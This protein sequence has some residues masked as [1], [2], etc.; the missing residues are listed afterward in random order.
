[1]TFHEQVHRQLRQQLAGADDPKT[2]N[3]ALRL[4]AKWRSALIQNTLLTHHGT[5]VMDGPFKGMRFLPHSAEGCH[6]PK[7]L[8][9]YEQPLVPHVERAVVSGYGTVLNIGCAE[10]YYAVGM[11]RRMPASRVMAFDLNP[12]AQETCKQLAHENDVS[13][14]VQVA[15]A[16]RLADFAAFTAQRVLVLCDIEGAER[17]L[18]DPAAAPAL[19]GMDLIVE[20]HECLVPGVTKTLIDRF[21]STHEITTVDDDGQRQ[22]ASPPTWFLQL[23]HLDQLLSTWEWRSGPTP[24][25]VMRSRQCASLQGYP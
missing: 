13:S 6:I 10:G 3:N 20:S 2:L 1:M 24:W 18:L 22:L 11:A 23:A 19:A 15:G 4:L 7:L 12:R 17:E 14:R 16:F 9:C 25:L 5:V 21:E 8:G